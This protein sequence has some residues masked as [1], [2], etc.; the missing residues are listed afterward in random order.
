MT[1]P[2]RRAD[3]G[4]AAVLALLLVAVNLRAA[5]A[6]VAPVLA[7][8]TAE[9]GLSSTQAGLLTTVPVVCFAAAAPPSA[10]L[11]RR[12]GVDRALSM[13][14]VAA[15]AAIAVRPVGGVAL[16]LV[17][18]AVIGAALTVGNVL[19]PVVIKRDYPLRVGRLT[20]W[21]TA[22]LILGAGLAAAVT[23]PLAALTGWRTALSAW[24]L[25]ALVGLL[26]WASVTRDRREAAE[27]VDVAPV[28]SGVGGRVW[29]NPVA[30]WIAA[31]LGAQSCTYFA[32][33]AWLVDLLRDRSGL[34]AAAAGLGMAV[35]QVL[36]IVGSLLLPPIAVRARQQ[37][38]IGLGVAAAWAASFAGLLLVPGWWVIWCVVA[39]LVQGAGLALAFA[40]IALRAADADA[41]RELSGMAQTVGYGLGALG[42]VLVGALAGTAGHWTAALLAML[43]VSAA[44]ALT[45][46][47]AGQPVTIG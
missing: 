1:T 36:G 11:A 4:S 35:F 26:A 15:A 19:V 12:I 2:G 37:G 40:L 29:R 24:S 33:T 25:L 42:P 32:L 21:Y 8:L 3:L 47:R 45:A 7:D 16:L 39:G 28:V 17:A 46:Y 13:A 41:A 6:S 20:A 18:S 10:W 23:A 44:M 5:I 31:F 30:W 34:D 43:V 38:W 27:G 22:A 14:L 9:L